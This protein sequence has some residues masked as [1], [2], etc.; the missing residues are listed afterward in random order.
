[1]TFMTSDDND[2]EPVAKRTHRKK[3]TIEDHKAT[4][5]QFV[6]LIGEMKGADF[7]SHDFAPL[8]SVPAASCQLKNMKRQGLVIVVGHAKYIKTRH[9][10]PIYRMCK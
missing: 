8:F 4:R 6:S 5:T 7:C 10:P 2:N 9:A 1:V 3:K